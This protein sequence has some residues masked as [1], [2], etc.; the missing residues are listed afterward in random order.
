MSL[1]VGGAIMHMGVDRCAVASLASVLH[2]LRGVPSKVAQRMVLPV[3][4]RRTGSVKGEA[5]RADAVQTALLALMPGEVADGRV[6]MASWALMMT[7]KW[8]WS[9]EWVARLEAG[10]RV[11]V[12]VFREP[13][14]EHGAGHVFVVWVQRG[15]SLGPWPCGWTTTLVSA[16]WLSCCRRCWGLGPCCA[17]G[18]GYLLSGC[19]AFATGRCL[20]SMIA[21]GRLASQ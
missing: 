6:T 21:H 5:V 12:I 13:S 15:R 4:G 3:F 8:R 18:R 17:S 19:G 9:R 20:G 7:G 14:N 1:V 11:G 10:H 2:T 16:R